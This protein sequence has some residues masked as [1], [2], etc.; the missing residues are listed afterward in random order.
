[1]HVS[2]PSHTLIRQ[3]FFLSILNPHVTPPLPSTTSGVLCIAISTCLL[4][5][6]LFPSLSN[7]KGLFG[8]RR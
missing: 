1:M 6:S 2:Y 8:Y 7:D 4:A 5:E 3:G